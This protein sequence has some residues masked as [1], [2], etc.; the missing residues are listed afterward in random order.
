[1]KKKI[2][3]HSIP[4]DIGI[5]IVITG[6]IIVCIFS[7]WFSGYKNASIITGLLGL[8]IWSFRTVLSRYFSSLDK[9]FDEQKEILLQGT[10]AGFGFKQTVMSDMYN[11]TNSLWSRSIWIAGNWNSLW[12]G[13]D[14]EVDQR[15]E[16]DLKYD[17]FI[18]YLKIISVNIPSKI[19]NAASSIIEGINTYQIGRMEREDEF[20]DDEAVRNRGR[21]MKKGA[22]MINDAMRNL[23]QLIRNE[24]GLDSLPGELIKI[25]QPPSED[26]SH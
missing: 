3:E 9:K 18:T 16:F 4:N 6:V 22:K 25:K 13:N 10:Q 11:K 17:E 5:L 23:F 26:E 24:F 7:L 12:P 20:A 8:A 1:M 21:E 15:K 14:T 19:Y 2:H